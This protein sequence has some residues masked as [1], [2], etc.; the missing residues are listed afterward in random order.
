MITLVIPGVHEQHSTVV[1]APATAYGGV[2]RAKP[3]FVFFGKNIWRKDSRS[4]VIE[5][6]SLEVKRVK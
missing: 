3:N 4:S 2:Q 5:K 1:P 6:D